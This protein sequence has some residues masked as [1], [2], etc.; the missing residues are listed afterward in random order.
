M[1][2]HHLA[3][4]QSMTRGTREVAV[5]GPEWREMAKAYWS[6]FR[7]HAVLAAG[8]T[9]RGEVPLLKHRFSASGA[10]RGFVCRD[11]VCDLPATSTAELISQ[12]DA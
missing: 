6:A 8:D 2:G 4:L 5:A 7:P 3:V 1:V 12:L 9:D 11:F 10:T